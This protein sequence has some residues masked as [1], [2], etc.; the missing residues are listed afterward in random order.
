MS[1]KRCINLLHVGPVSHLTR[2]SLFWLDWLANKPLASACLPPVAVAIAAYTMP[3]SVRLLEEIHTQI[4]T[5]PSK[6]PSRCWRNINTPPQPHYLAHSQR[7]SKAS[8]LC[9][10]SFPVHQ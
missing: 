1:P 4:L 7:C 3:A 9:P 2:D 10:T 5:L 8:T 6:L